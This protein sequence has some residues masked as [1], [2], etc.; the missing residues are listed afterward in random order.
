MKR[1]FLLGLTFILALSFTSIA[2]ATPVITDFS[3][4]TYGDPR[5]FPIEEGE[6]V[7][8]ILEGYDFDYDL[9][10]YEIDYEGDGT[11]DYSSSFGLFN[12]APHTFTE[13]GNYTS[14]GRITSTAGWT[15][16]ASISFTVI[17]KDSSLPVP[18]P[19]TMLLLGLGL[20]GLA[21]I[22]RKHFKI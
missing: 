3:I 21:G 11:Y 19:T 5:F 15:A 22:S 16:I 14:Y 8:Y 18:E 6:L 17:E 7:K 12:G 1:V 2:L 10:L 20:A 13:A 9:I 4:E